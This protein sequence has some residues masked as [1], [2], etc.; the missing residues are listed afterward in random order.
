MCVNGDKFLILFIYY[1]L[2]TQPKHTNSK[3]P[4]PYKIISQNDVKV[5]SYGYTEIK[6]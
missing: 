4:Q 1:V 6:E 3:N 5:E 2:K